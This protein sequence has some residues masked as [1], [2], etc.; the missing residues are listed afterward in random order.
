MLAIY[1]DMCSKGSLHTPTLLNRRLEKL[2]SRLRGEEGFE[3]CAVALP[4]G[5]D[6]PPRWTLHGRPHPMD[7]P[8]RRHR[9]R[10]FG[11]V[12]RR[13]GG[14]TCPFGRVQASLSKNTKV[15]QASV[16]DMTRL[17][18]VKSRHMVSVNQK[19]YM[20][21]GAGRGSRQPP[22]NTVA[23]QL[24]VIGKLCPRMCHWQTTKRLSNFHRHKVGTTLVIAP[25]FPESVRRG[26]NCSLPLTSGSIRMT[27][28]SSRPGSDRT[29]S[30]PIGL[31]GSTTIQ[32]GSRERTTSNRFSVRQIIARRNHER[33]RVAQRCGSHWCK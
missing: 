2:L 1:D 27:A 4:E 23:M 13:D 33:R 31:L 25:N 5:N 16:W 24:A 26:G 32:S 9:Y 17:V 20:L 22:A 12:G 29:Q 7:I 21:T 14:S 15:L 18:T 19:L 8:C 11:I 10:G 6:M 3:M 30:S 28:C